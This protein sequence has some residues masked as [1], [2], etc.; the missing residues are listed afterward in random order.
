[1]GGISGVAEMVC[2]IH[3]MNTADDDY[4]AKDGLSAS[5][6]IHTLDSQHVEQWFLN[7]G[8]ASR[9]ISVYCRLMIKVEIK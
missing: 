1:M 9:K 5:C 2:G 7:Y 6:R 8:E 3:V 4:F